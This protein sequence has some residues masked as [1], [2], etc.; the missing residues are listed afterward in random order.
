MSVPRTTKVCSA[1]L[2]T[3]LCRAVAECTELSCSC[4][5]I[6]WNKSLN[7][8]TGL[9]RLVYGISL[10]TLSLAS[11]DRPQNTRICQFQRTGVNH[12]KHCGYFTVPLASTLIYYALCPHS[13]WDSNEYNDELILL[14]K[15]ASSVWS[16]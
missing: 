10:K 3:T 2:C 4:E 13:S 15:T 11:P 14:I 12:L 1:A 9:W 5:G 6:S 8:E 7:E 16:V